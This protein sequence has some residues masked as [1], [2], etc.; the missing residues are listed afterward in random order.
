MILYDSMITVA[1]KWLEPAQDL[2]GPLWQNL[3]LANKKAR[4]KRKKKNQKYK[5]K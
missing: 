5:K 3:V 4:L 2:E 1:P